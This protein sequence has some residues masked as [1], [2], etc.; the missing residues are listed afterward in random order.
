MKRW[1]DK[2]EQNKYTVLLILVHCSVVI[3]GTEEDSV[4]EIKLNE[5]REAEGE[6]KEKKLL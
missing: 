3:C 2:K 4:K 6:W 5:I 1:K